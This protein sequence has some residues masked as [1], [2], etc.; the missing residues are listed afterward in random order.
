MEG[1]LVDVSMDVIGDPLCL[2]FNGSFL[3]DSTI[4]L[5]GKISLLPRLRLRTEKPCGLSK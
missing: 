2:E 5:G 3:E 1:S 4:E